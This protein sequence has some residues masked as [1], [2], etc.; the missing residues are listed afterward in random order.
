MDRSLTLAP[1]TFRRD[2]RGGVAIIFGISAMAITMFAGIALDYSRINHERSRVT[3]AID[4]ATLAAGKAMLDGRL[5]DDEVKQIARAYFDENVRG[6]GN[7]FGSLQSFDVQLDRSTNFVAINADV[8]VEMTLTRVAGYDNVVFPVRASAQFEQQDIELSMAL[9]VTGSM[10][11]FGKMEALKR[12]GK[13]LVRV[14]L[15]EE[16]TPNK[17]RIALAPYSSG[18]NAGEHF[19][20]ATGRASGTGCTFERDNAD[21]ASD[22]TPAAGSYLKTNGS[23]GVRAG[24]TCPGRG[25]MKLTDQRQRLI[26]EFDYYAPS[27]STAGHLGALWAWYMLSDKWNAALGNDAAPY[28]DGKTKKALVLMTDGLFNTIGGTNNGDNSAVARQSQQIAMDACAAMRAQDIMVFTVGFKLSEINNATLRERAETTLR[29]CSG[30]NNARHFD[31]DNEEGLISAFVAI[32]EQ[33]NNLRLT[34]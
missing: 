31:A 17:V 33:L 26:D 6:S 27:G 28:R 1:R 9:D 23:A 29:T 15:P 3:T 18:V 10:A 20:A 5:S 34:N 2:E 21:Q 24:A 13:E 8:K 12:A 32:A 11:P 4:A 25:V 14:M 16:G 19:T 7:G 22:A 30:N